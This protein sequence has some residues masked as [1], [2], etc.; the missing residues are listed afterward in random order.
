[1]A[2]NLV[3]VVKATDEHFEHIINTMR[4]IDRKEALLSNGLS[5]R[6]AM[7]FTRDTAIASFCALYDGVP[8]LVFGIGRRTPIDH[9]GVPWLVA[10]DMID[11]H[12][13]KLLKAARVYFD[14]MHKEFECMENYILA[15][16]VKSIRFLKWLGFE[17]DE[18]KR[19][20]V[21]NGLFIRFGKK[22]QCV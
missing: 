14:R 3:S 16:N 8:V 10:N 12:P 4:E 21:G 22:L 15:E 9:V 13:L 18:P 6:E 11:D 2:D 19:A 7:E 5:E 1:M 20:G 17:F